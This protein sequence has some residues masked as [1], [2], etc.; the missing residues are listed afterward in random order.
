MV[1]V[2]NSVVVGSAVAIAMGAIG[3][4][5]LGV[6]ATIG[7]LVAIVSLAALRRFETRYLRAGVGELEI[8]FPS[9]QS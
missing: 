8:L 1:A 6:A 3:D 5:S 9:P 2:I 7:G 4:P